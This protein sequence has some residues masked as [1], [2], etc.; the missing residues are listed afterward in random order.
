M[1]R[2]VALTA[3]AVLCVSLLASAFPVTVVDD[4]GVE[5][6]I[7]TA[8]ERIVVVGTLYAEILID[9]GLLDRV[10]AITDSDDN[11]PATINI[12][13]IGPAFSPSVELILGFDPDLVLGATD[14]GGERQALEEAGV[15]V[16]TTPWLTSVA[17]VFDTVRT[18]A[19][20]TGVS[21]EGDA[22][23]GRI[24]TEVVEAEAA[25]LGQPRTTVAFL[26]A[27]SADE[28]P[29][30]S[31]SDAIEHE[32]ILRAGGIN[33]F[34]EL[35]WSPQVGFEDILARDPAVIFTAPSQI[36][37][38]TGNP[39]LASVSAVANS[40]VFGI[41]A[42]VAASTHLPEALRAMIDALH[43]NDP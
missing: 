24:A 25:I 4:R 14:W 36:E 19:T 11:P 20:A 32:L 40:R 23:I 43:P 2:A 12:P 26:F 35:Q 37:N 13:S 16:L 27:A 9:L 5:V 18:L 31:G 39:L 22:I 28:P 15:T 6:V 8:P 3:V 38:I 1:R 17:S 30:A 10:V 21:E 34:E 33:V 42:S 41:R 7:E 29:Y